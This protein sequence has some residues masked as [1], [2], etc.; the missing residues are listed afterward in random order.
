MNANNNLGQTLKQARVAKG[1]TLLALSQESKVSP[2]FLARVERGERFPSGQVLRKLAH[3][4]GFEET[5]LY[6]LA[7]LLSPQTGE[8][9]NGQLD[10]YVSAVL[11]HETHKVQRAVVSIL[12]I[13]KTLAEASRPGQE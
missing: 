11:S 7:G 6:V 3:P 5:T 4:L 13:F 8:H 10:P 12:A 2:S 1:L 9:K